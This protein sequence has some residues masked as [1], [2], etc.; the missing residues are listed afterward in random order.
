MHIYIGGAGGFG[1]YIAKQLLQNNIHIEAFVD[2]HVLDDVLGITVIKPSD[3]VKEND[4]ICIVAI[5]DV[6]ARQS[7]VIDVLSTGYK[8][9]YIAD[10][11]VFFAEL[12]II[13]DEGEIEKGFLTHYSD[14]KPIFPYIEYHLA[15]TC[16]L[17]CRRCGHCA[18][19]ATDPG[20]PDID[21]FKE[22]LVNLKIIFSNIGR[23]RLMGG[24]PLLNRNYPAFV[25][26]VAEVFP[27][28]NLFIVTN[29]L[30]LTEQKDEDIYRVR[31]KAVF[32]IS[33]YPPTRKRMNE[34]ISW[35]NKMQ[36]T[37][38]VSQPVVSFFAGIS[39]KRDKK[40]IDHVFNSCISKECHF[41]RDTFLMPCAFPWIVEEYGGF[42]EIDATKNM[43]LKNIV[44]IGNLELDGW[45][46]LQ[47]YNYK[48]DYCIFCAGEYKMH[49]WRN[50][51][52]S[53]SAA[54]WYVD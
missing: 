4:S 47:K 33:Q 49:E 30:L 24:E 37:I 9:V 41:M 21:V 10:S 46:I 8:S 11:N 45:E 12:S 23:F 52:E 35:A 28:A 16:N 1:K 15:D 31:D 43:F 22:N 53:V 36:V 3:M 39:R 14:I 5:H 7:F 54:D 25:E 32:Q 20:F 44:D 42:L 26:A 29:G 40:N 18:N 34:I 48:N 50:G 2:N 17:K 19:I 13:D 6:F 38:Q 51:L 27:K